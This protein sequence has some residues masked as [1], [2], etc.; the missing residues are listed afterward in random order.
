MYYRLVRDYKNSIGETTVRKPRP[1][2]FDSAVLKES[3]DKIN[4]DVE[5]L[6]ESEF[7]NQLEAIRTAQKQLKYL[8]SLLETKM[9]NS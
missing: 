3:L 2:K 9:Q 1:T 5:N 4:Q 8:Q 6:P 7:K